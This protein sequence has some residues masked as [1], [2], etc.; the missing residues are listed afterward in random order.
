LDLRYHSFADYFV[1]ALI[2]LKQIR[3]QHEV[4]IQLKRQAPRAANSLEG[5]SSP[6]WVWPI[7]GHC[8]CTFFLPKAREVSGLERPLR[9]GKNVENPAE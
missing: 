6:R 2:Q 7:M 4:G 3:D 9:T 5:Y 1:I 8:W